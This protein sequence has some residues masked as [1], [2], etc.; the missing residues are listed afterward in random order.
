[1][2]ESE[3]DR[4]GKEKIAAG[5]AEAGKGRVKGGGEAGRGGPGHGA[6]P[7]KLTEG[8]AEAGSG[9]P[10]G[11][12][13][14]KPLRDRQGRGRVGTGT[15]GMRFAA[16]L[17]LAWGGVGGAEA[18]GQADQGQPV[19]PPVVRDDAPTGPSLSERLDRSKG[20]IVPPASTANTDPG[21]VKPAPSTGTRSMPVIPPP[22]TSGRDPNVQPK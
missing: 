22:G 7:G 4:A 6:G 1:M 3:K 19:A 17:L 21:L 13:P 14:K 20:V 2:A 5:M 11:E 16:A 15:L 9:A 8:M 18:R 12:A 10:S